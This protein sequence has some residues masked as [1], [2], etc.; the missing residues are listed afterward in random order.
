MRHI[1]TAPEVNVSARGGFVWG[2]SSEALYGLTTAS[3]EIAVSASESRNVS[4]EE[5]TAG[6]SARHV[7]SSVEWIQVRLVGTHRDRHI[8]TAGGNPFPLLANDNR[9]H[10]RGAV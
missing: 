4:R 1:W 6:G 2:S 9:G 8:V 5:D 7:D 3:S 10:H